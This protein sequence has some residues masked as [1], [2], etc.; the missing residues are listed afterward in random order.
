MTLWNRLRKKISAIYIENN[1]ALVCEMQRHNRMYGRIECTWKRAFFI[2]RLYLKYV[3]LR[4][5]PIIEFQKELECLE[6]PESKHC[7]RFTD[8]ELQKKVDAVDAVVFDAWD[9]LFIRT[10][11]RLQ[12]LSLFETVVRCPGIACYVQ[13]GGNLSKEQQAIMDNIEMDFTLDNEYIHEIWNMAL[14]RNKRVMV[15][16]N[17]L[18]H[19]D[20][21]VECLMKKYKYEGT[22][23]RESYDKT[24]VITTSAET[25][26]D[27][28]YL[29]VRSLGEK[30]RPYFREN[31]VTALYNQVINSKLHSKNEATEFFY[32]Y[33][34]VCGGLLV[35]GFCQYLNELAEKEKIDKFLFVARDGDIMQKIYNKYFAEKKQAYILFSRFASYEL[36]FEDYPEEYIDKNIR[37]RMYRHNTDN[38]IGNILKECHLEMLNKFLTEEELCVENA[39]DENSYAKLRMLILEHKQ[40][41]QESYKE[42]SEAA[43]T[44][45]M[46][47]VE[48][49]KKV[50]VVDL[51]WHGKSIVYLK[52]LLENKYQ[53]SGQVVGALVGGAC[54]E[55]TQNYIRQ[56]LINTYAYED[57]SWRHNGVNNGK[58]MTT[59]EVICIESLFSSEADTLLRYYFDENG[60]VD[61]IYGKPNRNKASMRQV[62]QGIMDFAQIFMPII[63]KY[64]LKIMARDA[65]TPLD[66]L[67]QNER[68]RNM[69]YQA[70]YEEPEAINGF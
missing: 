58:K 11:D 19:S 45:F 16:N 59:E 38:T 7:Q 63:E 17:S 34:L 20:E 21:Q 12:L 65:Y 53:W 61:F 46:K 35:C 23:Y 31:A 26:N 64:N 15:R 1:E 6:Y 54:D 3:V 14:Q 57:E 39:L 62:H 67:M 22:L 4:Q 70:Y 44:Y 28:H 30:Y 40:E 66:S 48:G 43:K 60:T 10:L 37:P 42:T 69:I 32:E 9:V 52:H 33:G 41:V 68:Y 8:D 5:N 27:I 29:N 24:L 55:V 36:I 13:E 56:G 51:G 50:C 2:M 18:N 49:C 47:Q 25:K